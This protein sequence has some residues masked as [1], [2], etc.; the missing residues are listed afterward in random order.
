MTKYTY[1]R[2]NLKWEGIWNELRHHIQQWRKD[3]NLSLNDKVSISFRTKSEEKNVTATLVVVN[4]YGCDVKQF[5]L[6]KMAIEPF[7]SQIN[8]NILAAGASFLGERSLLH[9]VRVTNETTSE[10][11][12]W[13]NN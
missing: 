1:L 10:E 9:S 4:G 13:S 8:W 2:N 6:N 7:D 11:V 12:V 5:D 3:L